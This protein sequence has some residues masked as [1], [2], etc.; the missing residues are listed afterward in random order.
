MVCKASTYLLHCFVTNLLIGFT[1]FAVVYQW[2]RLQRSK[3][4]HVA[5]STY[6]CHII[7]IYIVVLNSL[8]ILHNDIW[9]FHNEIHLSV[10]DCCVTWNNVHLHKCFRETDFSIKDELVCFHRLPL[11]K[12]I[13]EVFVIFCSL[14]TVY[15]I[16]GRCLTLEEDRKCVFP[17]FL[18][19]LLIC[20]LPMQ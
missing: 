8:D 9:H 1:L 5:S 4:T 19:R 14:S 16:K 11:Y 15:D 2:H 12:C 13:N 7:V 20:H 3:E 17:W 6:S 18:Q 10:W